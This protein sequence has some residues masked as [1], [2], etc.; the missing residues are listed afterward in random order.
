SIVAFAIAYS[1][2]AGLWKIPFL[3][4]GFIREKTIDFFDISF[5]IFASSLSGIL[6]TL[7]KQSTSK[8]GA[9]CG[10]LIAGLISAACPACQ[11]ITLIALGGTVAAVR[12]EWLIPYLGLVK[13]VSLLVLLLAILLVA[14]T[15]YTKTCLS[16]SVGNQKTRKNI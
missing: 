5:I 7:T 15:S 4:I 8:L 9:T 16:C 3:G 10:S 12:F 11:G 1:F 14:N 2:L 13:I 6:F